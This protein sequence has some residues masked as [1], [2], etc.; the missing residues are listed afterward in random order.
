MVNRLEPILRYL[1]PL[2]ARLF[3]RQRSRQLR[4][5]RN[6]ERCR[7]AI[8]DS[9]AHGGV[10]TRPR[11]AMRVV[12]NGLE[13]RCGNATAAGF[14]FV[15]CASATTVN[16][17]RSGSALRHASIERARPP[18]Q[19]ARISPSSVPA[20]R[21]RRGREPPCPGE[22]H[23]ASLTAD[24]CAVIRRS[25]RCPADDRRATREHIRT[26]RPMNDCDPAGGCVRSVEYRA[27]VRRLATNTR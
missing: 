17:T 21:R 9:A 2:A 6:G 10:V 15:C 8:R 14:R 13:L 16:Y 1:K 18:W 4:V 7:C 12:V 11:S 24:E 20:C 26:Q 19:M 27:S 22:L 25:P 3:K 5:S 23:A